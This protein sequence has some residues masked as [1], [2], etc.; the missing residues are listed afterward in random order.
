MPAI[1]VELRTEQSMRGADGPE[2]V[3]DL[4]LVERRRVG[5]AFPCVPVGSLELTREQVAA[6]LYAQRE[7]LPDLPRHPTDVELLKALERALDTV[8]LAGLEEARQELEALPLDDR[9]ASSAYSRA[10][11]LCVEHWYTDAL[12]APLTAGEL[13]L[14]LYASD[15]KVTRGRS[16][17]NRLAE[18]DG[19]LMEGVARLGARTLALL[20]DEV[21]REFDHPAYRV[22][23]G[24]LSEQYQALMPD[25]R[26]RRFCHDL[27]VS[28]QWAAPRPLMVMFDA[29]GFAVGATPPECP[30]RVAFHR[31]YLPKSTLGRA[32]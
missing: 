26:R 31:A 19:H 7:T 10:Y 11:R 8:G 2:Q 1:R 16:V 30:R 6:G 13:T 18:V 12:S 22:P 27:A 17:D 9:A 25:E 32:A 14:A 21:G 28:R 15:I 5:E 20:G 23:F 4:P 3:S 29:G 24:E